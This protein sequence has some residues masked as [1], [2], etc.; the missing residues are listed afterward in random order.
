[1]GIISLEQTN[2]LYWLGRY[3]ERVYTTIRL[4]S[5]CYDDMIDDIGDNYADFCRMLEI[6]NIYRDKEDFNQRYGF[7]ETDPNSILSN[8]MRAYDNAVVLREEIGSE[9][10][11]YIQLAIYAINKAK[12][13]RAP[14]LELQNVEDNI[15]AFWGIADDFIESETIRNIIRTGKRVE[16]IDL[17]ARLKLGVKELKSELRRMH[18]R[19]VSSG[20]S[21]DRVCLDSLI[22]L[23]EHIDETAEV[24]YAGI[25][26]N[27]E[28]LVLV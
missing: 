6:P 2:R 5:K 12:I 24:D 15:L 19:L 1:M 8:L 18:T 11:S 22:V 26:R 28:N 13:S 20:M 16:R 27:V 4:Y 9:T 14:L 3:S 17:Y 21:Y 25:V 23:I 10:L 7:D